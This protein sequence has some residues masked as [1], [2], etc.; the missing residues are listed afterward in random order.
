[1]SSDLASLKCV[2]CQGGIPPM[3][4]EELETY[5][6][7][8]PEWEVV[9]GHHISRSFGFPD[10]QSALEFAQ[11]IGALAEREGHHPELVLRWGLVQVNLWTHKIEGLAQADFV[12]AAKI[13][14]L[15]KTRG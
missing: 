1:M 14:Q 5:A 6:R 2:P 8:L 13:D 3:A 12:L 7:Q 11:Q 15:W 9:R 4:G 10:F